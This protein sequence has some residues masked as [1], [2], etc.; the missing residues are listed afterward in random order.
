MMQMG[1]KIW[2]FFWKFFQLAS[3]A[4]LIIKQQFKNQY[5]LRNKNEKQCIIAE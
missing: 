1:C 4:F 5:Y 2:I 3:L